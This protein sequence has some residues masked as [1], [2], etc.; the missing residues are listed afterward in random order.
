MGE[1]AAGCS[2]GD[3]GVCA[4]AG[5]VPDVESGRGGGRCVHRAWTQQ[6][7]R[8]ERQRSAAVGR[9]P[10]DGATSW[11][12]AVRRRPGVV[13]AASGQR[14]ARRTGEGAAASWREVVRRRPGEAAA[15]SGQRAARRT[16][17]KGAV[18]PWQ[19]AARRLPG[20]VAA[21]TGQRV[22]GR[23]G[24]LLRRGSR[25]RGRWGVR[26]G[27]GTPAT[28]G[29]GPAAAAGGPSPCRL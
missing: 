25:R 12:E 9:G 11:R 24:V 27:E 17:R 26:E 14:A 28:G 21:A 8:T 18:A 1:L 16:G 5:D 6:G 22:G 29:G 15:A 23:G 4:R 7:D 13:A 2:G 3:G 19:R 10:A 20:A